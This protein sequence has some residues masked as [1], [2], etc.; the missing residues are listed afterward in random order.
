MGEYCINNDSQ[1]QKDER[2]LASWGP[3]SIMEMVVNEGKACI[4]IHIC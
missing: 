3:N 2:V 1:H 4:Y